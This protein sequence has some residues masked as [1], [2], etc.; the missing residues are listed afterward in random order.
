MISTETHCRFHIGGIRPIEG[1]GGRFILSVPTG[2]GKKSKTIIGFIIDVDRSLIS[3]F[4]SAAPL[5]K[6]YVLLNIDHFALDH[7]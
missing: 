5:T 3:D 6:L 2:Q 7:S 4:I 1:V